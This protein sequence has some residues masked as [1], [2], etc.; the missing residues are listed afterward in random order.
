MPYGF[1]MRAAAKPTRLGF[2]KCSVSAGALIHGVGLV[3]GFFTAKEFEKNLPKIA[4]FYRLHT[5]GR[6]C[7][8]TRA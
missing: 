5:G 8:Q 2:G 7:R 4:G 1:G 6:L 3:A